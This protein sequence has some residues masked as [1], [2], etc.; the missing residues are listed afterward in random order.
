MGDVKM[1]TQLPRLVDDSKIIRGRIFNVA[2]INTNSRPL[3]FLE[4]VENE[5]FKIIKKPD[6]LEGKIDSKTGKK[7][8]EVLQMVTNVKLRPAI[9]IQIDK[10][11]NKVSYPFVV[12]LPL[13]NIPKSKKD[14]YTMKRIIEKNDLDS[15][16]Y[17]GHNSYVTVND[18]SRV[19]KNM[20]FEF[21]DGVER[22][23]NDD[24]LEIIMKKF[25][26]C[27]GIK[28]IEKCDE[29][30]YNY[31]N[32]ESEVTLEQVVAVDSTED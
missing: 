27:F 26:N 8:A 30:I 20:L 2:I 5:T 24:V 13:A 18:P 29:C 10:D 4:K 6:G 12:I 1:D 31:N 14:T 25:A 9:V 15:L 23:I 17:L 3:G 11:N 16:H 21:D 7:K 28:K 22:K 32:F 19:Y